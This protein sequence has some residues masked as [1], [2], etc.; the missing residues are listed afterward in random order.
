MGCDELIILG[1]VMSLL[2]G[3]GSN[4]DTIGIGLSYGTHKTRIPWLF[5]IIVSVLSFCACLIGALTAKRTDD[6][7]SPHASSLIGSCIFI[8]IGLW[9]AIQSFFSADTSSVD[10]RLIRFHEMMII[11]TA[12]AMG[13]LSIGFASGFI[14]MNGWITATSVGIFSMT[15]LLLPSL[16]RRWIPVKYTEHARFLSGVLLVVVGLID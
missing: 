16:A 7:V 10:S 14:D 1:V 4:L 3:I 11:G 5:C 13:N 2:L 15:F 12:Q 8:A 6:I 9:I